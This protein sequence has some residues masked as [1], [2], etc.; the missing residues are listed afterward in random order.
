V[1]QRLLDGGAKTTAQLQGTPMLVLAASSNC[2]EA[3]DVL[4]A[5][6]ADVNGADEDGTTALMHAAALGFVPIVQRLLDKGANLEQTNKD[7]QSAW[8]MAAM[9]NQMEVVDI[10]K[11]YRAA[12]PPP[13]LR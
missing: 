9:G 7:R 6:G 3:I 12:H 8:I 11:A 1:M 4:I 2:L 5:R 13:E 10:F